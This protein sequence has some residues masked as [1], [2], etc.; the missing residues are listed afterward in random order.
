MLEKV[1]LGDTVLVRYGGRS[2]NAKISGFYVD[3]YGG[4]KFPSK[5]IRFITEAIR[6]NHDS[7]G[8]L[9][10]FGERKEAPYLCDWIKEVVK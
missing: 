6:I 10:D 3:G 2:F 1:N 4:E 7:C 5:S 8:A 9:L